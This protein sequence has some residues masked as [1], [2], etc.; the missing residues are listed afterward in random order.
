[1][2]HS[3]NSGGRRWK[4]LR[5]NSRLKKVASAFSNWLAVLLWLKNCFCSCR[6][7]LTSD[8]RFFSWSPISWDI[9]GSFEVDAKNL[10]GD[11]AT[12]FKQ[13]IDQLVC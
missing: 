8:A 11:N 2:G 9:H 13:L 4:T 1:M 12:S 5:G 6:I 10:L 7:F 3:G